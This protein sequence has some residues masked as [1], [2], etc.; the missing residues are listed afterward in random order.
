MHTTTAARTDTT[1]I[2]SATDNDGVAFAYRLTQDGRVLISW[3][4]RL[5][6]TVAGAAADRLRARL[7]GADP[8]QIQLALA[9]ATGNFKRGNERR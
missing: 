8:A 2:M 7:Q 1:T 5:V 9:K 3:R 6:T 4:G